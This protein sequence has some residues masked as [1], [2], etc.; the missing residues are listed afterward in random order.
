MLPFGPAGEIIKKKIGQLFNDIPNVF[1]IADDILFAGFDADGRDHDAS[2][3]QMLWSCRQASLK[4]TKEKCLFRWTR[5]PFFVKVI[6]RHE[7]SP[8]S[9]KVKALTDIIPPKIKRELQSLLGIVNYLSK[10][11]PII[12]EVCEPPRKLTSVNA[13]WTWK[14][15]YKKIFERAKSL[16]KGDTCMR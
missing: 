12:A 6:S 5:I 9:A 1:G 10:F 14:R 16:V 7:V 3:Q 8:D 15:S 13:A 2:L 4:M 11:S